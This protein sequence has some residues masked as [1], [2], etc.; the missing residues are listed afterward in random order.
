MSSA[1]NT[2]YSDSL[3]WFT[4]SHSS[5]QGGNCV[6]I[7]LAPGAVHVRDSKDR[8]GPQLAFAPDEWAAFVS[9]ATGPD[10]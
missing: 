4:S 1:A 5:D 8:Q 10:A 6:E 9:F 3:T 7:A 2:S